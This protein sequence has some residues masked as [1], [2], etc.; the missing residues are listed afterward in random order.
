MFTTELLGRTSRSRWADSLVIDYRFLVK[1][2][3][4]LTNFLPSGMP[5]GA[6]TV[7]AAGGVVHTFEPVHNTP[8][9]RYDGA[10]KFP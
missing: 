5:I 7:A 6:L 10:L 3:D 9:N 2:P 8:R 4:D 1:T